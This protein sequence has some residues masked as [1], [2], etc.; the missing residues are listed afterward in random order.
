MIEEE[1]MKSKSVI[2]LFFCLV[3]SI[4]MLAENI[5]NPDKVLE[6]KQPFSLRLSPDGEWVVFW[7]ASSDGASCFQLT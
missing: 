5:W 2:I 1:N 3:C 7:L 4:S 6:I